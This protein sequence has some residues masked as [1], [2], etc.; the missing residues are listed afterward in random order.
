MKTVQSFADQIGLSCEVEWV[1]ANPHMDD[2]PRGSNHFL[3]TLARDND[4]E[5]NVYFS[6]GPALCREPEAVEVL[7]CLISDSRGVVDEGFEDWADNYGYDSDSRKA[8]RTY[9]V[10]REQ[11]VKL[12]AFLGEDFGEAF[13]VEGL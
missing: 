4:Q 3:V 9:L 13:E 10:C 2:M 12:E 6:M 5:M 1:D 11:A 7:D 8:E